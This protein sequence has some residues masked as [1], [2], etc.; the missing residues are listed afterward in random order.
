MITH[1]GDSKG[2][3]LGRVERFGAHVRSAPCVHHTLQKSTAPPPC[4]SPPHPNPSSETPRSI[5][6]V[7]P[8]VKMVEDVCFIVFPSK[9]CG[10]RKG[11]S[12]TARPHVAHHMSGVAHRTACSLHVCRCRD[13]ISPALSSSHFPPVDAFASA[14]WHSTNERTN[15]RTA[16]SQNKVGGLIA[17]I[18]ERRLDGGY[19][20][21]APEVCTLPSRTPGTFLR[22]R[23]QLHK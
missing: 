14:L 19:Q 11:L 15:G 12:S 10:T 1:G 22:L 9:N 18:M 7:A 3:G 13:P 23:F 5:P 21:F 2:I 8:L 4:S 20:I 17:G 16:R 6:L